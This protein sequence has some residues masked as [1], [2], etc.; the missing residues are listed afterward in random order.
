MKRFSVK[1]LLACL[2][3]MTLLTGC[4]VIGLDVET[5]LMPP[6]SNSEHKAIRA[7][8]DEYI[9]THTK[10]G[11]SADYTLKYP[12]GG[13][14]LSA[15]I[16]L[17]QVKEHTVLTAGN[18]VPTAEKPVETKSALAFY[19]R[20][21]EN[22][23]VHINLLKSNDEGQWR[24]VADIEGKGESVN[25]VE[26]GDLNNDGT[27]ELLI[28]WSLYNT[29]DSRLAIYNID[30]KLTMRSFSATYTD[31]V[32]ADITADGSD[33]LLLLS[34]ANS[35]DLVSAQMF[36]FR[37]DNVVDSG[38]ALL[39]SDIIRFGDHIT[40]SFDNRFNGVFLDCYK[41]QDAMVTELLCW[42]DKKL[43]APLC[44]QS[45]QLN[46][47]TARE[48]SLSCRDIDGDGMVEWPITTRMPGFEETE[49]NQTLWYTEWCSYDLQSNEVRTEFFGLMP[50][51]DGYMLRLREE[52]QTLPAAYSRDNRTLTLY[53]KENGGE[54]LFRIGT[55]AASEKNDL[56][57]GYVLFHEQKDRCYAVLM[58]ED[59]E[60]ISLEEIRHLF[61]VLDGEDAE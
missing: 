16:M 47:H 55:F 10:N 14:Y 31:L 40:V 24:S 34:I 38:H 7:A 35:F 23:L 42:Q 18:A 61:Y 4:N 46:T 22:A 11:Q 53:R 13:R 29:R 51:K 3:I 48:I 49:P 39:D 45:T 30:E 21:D 15:F 54:W 6:E 8:L 19:R 17:D 25:Q 43:I 27:P 50:A 44:N 12:S 1:P 28:G 36:S 58:A 37:T 56:P 32:V 52:W 60:A 2:L 33:D 57:D 20:N 26:F 59:T 9:G 41:E 5:Q